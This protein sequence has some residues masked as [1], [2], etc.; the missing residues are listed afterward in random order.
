[1][2]LQSLRQLITLKASEGAKSGGDTMG[3]HLPTV[4]EL[5]IGQCNADDEGVRSMVAECLGRLALI[6][7]A[8]VL[9]ALKALLTKEE[10]ETRAT[11][12]YSLKFTITDRA[13]LK[14]LAA[15]ITDFLL[16]LKDPEIMVRRAAL[17]TLNSATH[18]KPS[19]IRPVLRSDWLLPALYG[20]TVYKQ[21]LVRT[22]NLG[23]FQHK[24]DDGAELRK[25]SLACMDTLFDKCADKLDTSTFLLHL[26]DRLSDELD[27]MKQAAYQLLCKLAVREPFFVREVMHLLTG[28]FGRRRCL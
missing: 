10:P 20:E 4:M 27:D 22:V 14:E 16:L 1:M 19:L 28:C 17:T 9:P 8:H 7:P 3:G 23:P 26:Q 13:P 5:L 15:C 25:L 11:V 18:N 2:L 24:V 12:V 6:A 21:E